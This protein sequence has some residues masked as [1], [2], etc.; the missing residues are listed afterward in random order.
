MAPLPSFIPSPTSILAVEF[1]SCVDG[2]DGASC[3]LCCR[4]VLESQMEM[5]VD[6]WGV[7]VR[8]REEKRKRDGG[9]WR[10]EIELGFGFPGARRLLS[11]RGE[12]EWNWGVKLRLCATHMRAA[13]QEVTCLA[14]EGG[15]WVGFLPLG[16]FFF[17][18]PNNKMELG[19]VWV[20]SVQFFIPDILVI[21]FPHFLALFQNYSKPN[22]IK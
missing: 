16:W 11:S 19:W 13:G 22:K 21:F 7:L 20:N 9:W 8:E 4:P 1:M 18:G 12:R 2:G 17:I 10:L 15:N 3:V 14:R 6:V 5:M